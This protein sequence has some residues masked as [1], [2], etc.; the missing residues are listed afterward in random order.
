MLLGFV[1]LGAVVMW[2]TSNNNMRL[3][4]ARVAKELA[5]FS[6]PIPRALALADS[7]AELRTHIAAGQQGDVPRLPSQIMV[8]GAM[9]AFDRAQLLRVFLRIG[10][11]SGTPLLWCPADGTGCRDLVAT[12]VSG[13]PMLLDPVHGGAL[14]KDSTTFLSYDDLPA[15]EVSGWPSSLPRG[16]GTLKAMGI[17]DAWPA[18]LDR[19]DQMMA[20]AFSLAFLIGLILVRWRAGKTPNDPYSQGKEG[21]KARIQQAGRLALEMQAEDCHR[22]DDE[23]TRAAENADAFLAEVETQEAMR[24]MVGA[25]AERG[26]AEADP[27]DHQLRHLDERDGEASDRDHKGS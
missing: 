27:G 8:R 11:L 24:E 20:Y 7:V 23:L 2:F 9:D 16:F 4:S 17:W 21:A 15:A 14:R 1:L 3:L 5:P 22:N 10:G 6:E 18:L 26:L 13:R 19:P 12:E 25:A